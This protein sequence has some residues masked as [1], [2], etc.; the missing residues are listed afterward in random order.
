MAKV[1][2]V[3]VIIIIETVGISVILVGQT[4]GLS[5]EGDIELGRHL[6]VM[7]EWFHKSVAIN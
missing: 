6:Y 4:A 2:P 7:R 3:I 1:I 5:G